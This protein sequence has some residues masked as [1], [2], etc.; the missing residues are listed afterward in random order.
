MS[1]FVCLNKDCK[2]GAAG[3]PL[4]IETDTFPPPGWLQVK[5]SANFGPP[6]G[7]QAIIQ[8]VCCPDC[9]QMFRRFN[10]DSNY[11]PPPPVAKDPN[12]AAPGETQNLATSDVQTITAGDIGNAATV[13]G[14]AK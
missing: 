1:K 9:M 10:G 12:E 5:A 7:V 2:T 8:G 14:G 11:T 13:L 4:V 6:K 3:G